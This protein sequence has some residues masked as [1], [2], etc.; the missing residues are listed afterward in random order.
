M[1]V[2]DKKQGAEM[3]KNG[4]T[5][6]LVTSRVARKKPPVITKV[7]RKGTPPRAS[8]GGFALKC[9]QTTINTARDIGIS[10]PRPEGAAGLV[11]AV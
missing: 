9:L 6:P 8:A 4:L 10:Q 7:S 5:E 11:R 3:A 1:H 2:S